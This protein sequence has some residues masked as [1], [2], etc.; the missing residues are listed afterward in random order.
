M[1]LSTRSRYGVRAVLELGI[2]YGKGPVQIKTISERQGIS[3]KYLEQLM[4][5]LKSAGL[6]KSIRGPKGGYFLAKE[7]SKVRL[8]EVFK[9]LEGPFAVVG[10][11]ED[12]DYCPR[13]S[14]C[15]TRSLWCQVQ[16]AIEDTLQSNT[17]Q[18]LVDKALA[19]TAMANY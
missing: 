10:C 14:D 12:A 8:D 5:L 1:K 3:N 6:V 13:Y 7:P 18:D 17:V 19:K 2:E 11:I 16:K 9:V 15:V 4:A